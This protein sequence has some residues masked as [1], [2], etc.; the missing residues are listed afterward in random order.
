MNPIDF[1]QA[2]RTFTGPRE[3]GAPTPTP[4]RKQTAEMAEFVLLEE[5]D[6]QTR[7]LVLHGTAEEVREVAAREGSKDPE[8]AV[9][10]AAAIK[11]LIE[12]IRKWGSG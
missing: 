4:Y 11:D 12:T 2:N 6:G 3:G 5:M 9:Q 8:G 7:D 10:H 1:P